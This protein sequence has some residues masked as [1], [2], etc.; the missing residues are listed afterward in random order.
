MKIRA[1]AAAALALALGV[2]LTGCN[3]FSPQR[4]EM[5]YDASDGIS[6]DLGG[7]TVQNALL[8]TTETASDANFL[9]T[10]VNLTDAE[11]TVSAQVGS[12]IVAKSIS[13][14]ANE[15]LLEVGSGEE[16]P[17]LVNGDFVTGTTI[18]VTF[19]SEYTDAEGNA[20]TAEQ[21]VFVPILGSDDAKDVLEEYATLL[22][23]E[24]AEETSAPAATTEGEPVEGEPVE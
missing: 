22:P 15:N 4:T 18:E 5:E 19:T 23:Q 1:V 10:A 20:Q 8:L 3:M 12:S 17:E 21:T 14:N 2:G 7:V 11:A 6:A 13:P 24:P 9:F 16:G